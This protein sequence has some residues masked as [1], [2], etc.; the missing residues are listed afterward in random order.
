MCRTD[1]RNIIIITVCPDLQTLRHPNSQI[2]R[3]SGVHTAK[4]DKS[5]R[6]SSISL[7]HHDREDPSLW[8][9]VLSNLLCLQTQIR[10]IISHSYPCR[11]T[12]TVFC[13]FEI[14]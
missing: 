7:N 8:N 1:H 9:V 14:F 10:L 5:E 4:S 2:P 13:L 3:F 11:L 12:F 6:C